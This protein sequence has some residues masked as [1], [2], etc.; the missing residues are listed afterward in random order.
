VLLLLVDLLLWYLLLLVPC[1]VVK[2]EEKGNHPVEEGSRC[3]CHLCWCGSCVAVGYSV[4]LCVGVG[5]RVPI[6]Q[7]I[8]AIYPGDFVEL[9]ICVLLGV[10]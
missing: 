3:V 8:Y 7:G 10:S 9:E 4:A 1:S 6:A 2:K 5:E